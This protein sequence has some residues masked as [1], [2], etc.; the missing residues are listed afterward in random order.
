M[1]SD[2]TAVDE[3]SEKP[4]I[5][6]NGPKKL[7]GWGRFKAKTTEPPPVVV[8]PLN[9][10][11][12][13]DERTG[14]ATESIK[15]ETSD[16][17]EDKPV[18]T[19]KLSTSLD[20]KNLL[21]KR[22][23]SYSKSDERRGSNDQRRGSNCKLEDQRQGSISRLDDPRPGSNTRLDDHRRGSSTKSEDLRRNSTRSFE[24]QRS[25]SKE[26]SVETERIIQSLS[27]FKVSKMIILL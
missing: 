15:E 27:E 16:T 11:R 23:E 22:R 20:V 24:L 25:S 2:L 17:T 10:G 9:P 12:K 1:S 5:T 4:L 7:G 14:S 26:P 19:S 3:N 8:D 18:I 21:A 6:S 13:G